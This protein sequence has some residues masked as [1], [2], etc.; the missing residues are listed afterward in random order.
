M[1]FDRA[2]ERLGVGQVLLAFKAYDVELPPLPIVQPNGEVVEV[3]Y[4]A[5]TDPALIAENGN[6][7]R[8]VAQRYDF[9]VKD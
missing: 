5:L 6:V 8:S 4:L 7:M 2:I 9:L 1:D 3:P